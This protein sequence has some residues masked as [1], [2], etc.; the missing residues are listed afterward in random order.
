MAAGQMQSSF[1]VASGDGAHWQH[2]YHY[3]RVLPLH[4]PLCQAYD[5]MSVFK[6]PQ[7][8]RIYQAGICATREARVP[9]LE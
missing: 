6:C 5:L 8:P 1:D 9:R 3:C 4:R 2:V 7:T